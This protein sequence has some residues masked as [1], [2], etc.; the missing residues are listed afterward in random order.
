MNKL[1]GWLEKNFVPVAAKIG[2]QRHLVAIRDA[3]AGIMPL[4]IAGSMAVL[5]N[6]MQFTPD[7]ATDPYQVMMNNLFGSADNP[8]QWKAFAGHVWSGSFA[9]ISVFIAFISAYNLAKSEDGNAIGAGCVSLA[10]F[11]VWGGAGNAG[12]LGLFVAIICG[13]GIGEIFLRLSKV[14]KLV[15][16]MPEGVPPGVAKAFAALMPTLIIMTVTG[17]FQYFVILGGNDIF[18]FINTTVQTPIRNLGNTLGAALFIPFF[19]QLLWFFGLH[20][21][22][23]IEPVMQSVFVPAAIENGELI[24]A[25]QQAKWIVTKPFYDAF[26]NMG[27]S[28]T[29]IAL[30]A[31]IFVGSKRKEHKMV[32]GLSAAPGLFNINESMM[33]GLPMVLN[34]LM[35][36][37]FILVPLVLT[38]IAYLA[39]AAGIVPM[40][41]I[42]IPWVCP[43]ILGGFLA[44]GGNLMGALLS[45]INLTIA[46]FIYLPFVQM[47]NRQGAKN[48]KAAA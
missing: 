17:L 28:G 11:Y 36:I 20:G 35:M 4:L 41:S 3:F 19:Q 48:D 12:A 23:I 5:I 45:A 44:T 7:Q 25:G 29:T 6:A 40:T 43:P 37:P 31:A 39:T 32:A 26:V 47:A 33:F 10:V 1:I 27:G 16:K 2:A 14:D 9:V 38:L 30:I 8:T 13:L 22:N 15:V 34:P 24:L 18:V 42:F 21:S 46:F